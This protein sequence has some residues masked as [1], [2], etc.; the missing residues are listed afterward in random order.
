MFA[1]WVAALRRPLQQCQGGWTRDVSLRFCSRQYGPPR[2]GSAGDCTEL[3]SRLPACSVMWQTPGPPH[4]LR[5]RVLESACNVGVV[6]LQQHVHL[7]ACP[8]PGVLKG[9][10]CR[11]PLGRVCKQ[12]CQRGTPAQLVSCCSEWPIPCSCG[13]SHTILL[14]P[15]VAAHQP[16]WAVLWH[17][18]HTDKNSCCCCPGSQLMAAPRERI[19]D[20]TYLPLEG[21]GAGHSSWGTAQVAVCSPRCVSS[22]PKQR[23]AWEYQGGN[24]AAAAFGGCAAG[25]W[26]AL[27][28]PMQPKPAAG[29]TDPTA[30]HKH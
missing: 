6:A 9:L 12:E 8:A 3:T 5:W 10:L 27:P 30:V 16:F 11:G 26:S 19:C 21:A 25:R 28:C 7:Q 14:P 29:R 13:I 17:W 4:L 1:L 15:P 24:A 23:T 18:P 2:R 22:A 20:S